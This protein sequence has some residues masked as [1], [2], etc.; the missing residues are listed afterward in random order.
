[1]LAPVA[2]VQIATWNG[3]GFVAVL[4]HPG[5]PKNAVI[6]VGTPS[7]VMQVVKQRPAHAIV[8]KRKRRSLRQRD[9]FGDESKRSAFWQARSYDFKRMDDEEARGEAPVFQRDQKL[10]RPA[11]R[12]GSLAARTSWAAFWHGK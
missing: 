8:P 9:L 5:P 10:G 6:T 4:K 11:M 3:Y 12:F 7:T 1:M 2:A